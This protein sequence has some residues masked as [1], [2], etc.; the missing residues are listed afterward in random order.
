MFIL[1]SVGKLVEASEQNTTFENLKNLFE[2][3]YECVLLGL[4]GSYGDIIF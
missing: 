2:F 1:C 3:N 4:V